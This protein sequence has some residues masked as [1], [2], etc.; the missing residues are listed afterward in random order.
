MINYH[1]WINHRKLISLCLNWSYNPRHNQADGLTHYQIVSDLCSSLHQLKQIHWRHWV[2]TSLRMICH[3]YRHEHLAALTR[4]FFGGAKGQ[5]LHKHQPSTLSKFKSIYRC[6][7][8]ATS[9]H[10]IN[11]VGLMQIHWRHRVLTS[12]RMVFLSEGIS[13]RS[14]LKCAN[15]LRILEWPG[16]GNHTSEPKELIKTYTITQNQ[17]LK[18]I[19]A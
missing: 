2:L 18:P 7:K 14:L 11:N 3:C 12:L 13:L 16:G 19:T 1:I 17:V 8:F 9:L 4:S 10:I 15:G 6:R 5:D